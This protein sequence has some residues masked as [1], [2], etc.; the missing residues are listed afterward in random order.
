MKNNKLIPKDKM[1]TDYISKKLKNIILKN[2]KKIAYFI[3]NLLI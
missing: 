1:K 3:K 2:P